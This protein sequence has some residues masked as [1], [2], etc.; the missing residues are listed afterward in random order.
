MNMPQYNVAPIKLENLLIDLQNPRYDPRTSQR[1]ALATIA[2]DQG[3]KLYN[4]AEDIL[5][6]GINPSDLPIVA[7]IEEPGFYIVMEGNRRVAA[8]KLLSSSALLSSLG[9]TPALL[10]KYNALL[11]RVEGVLP[12]ELHCVVLSREDANY[13]IMLKHTGENEGVGIVPWDG[14][15]SHR[16]RG[17]SPALQAVELVESSGLLDDDTMVKIP[18]IAITNIERILGTPEARRSLGVEVKN[19]RL[20]L[21]SPEDNALARLALV[22]SDVANRVVRVTDLDTKDQRVQ[23]A[24]E[25]AGRPLLAPPKKTSGSPTPQPW[26]PPSPGRIAPQRNSLIPRH[27]KIR[28]PQTR[29]NRIYSE[30]QR[31]NADHYVNSCAVLLRVFVELTVDDYAQRHRVSLKVV[32]KSRTGHKSASQPRDMTLREKLKTLSAILEAKKV[33]TKQEL[34]GV[35]ALISNRN[36]VLSVDTLNAYVHNKDYTP[37]PIDLKTTWDNIQAFIEHLWGP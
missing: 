20:I 25:V 31:L 13:W 17:A 3:I 22:V 24:K 29:V 23:Y 34:Q 28:I 33:C 19:D 30:L 1:D 26:K 5:D 36:H 10:K 14:R 11:E 27:V 8:L 12:T 32:P 21:A 16:F 15:A 2:R 37:T 9:L 35:R 18:K 7:S 6:K 4:L